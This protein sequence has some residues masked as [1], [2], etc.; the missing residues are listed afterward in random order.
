[1]Y[2]R[3]DINLLVEELE[4]KLYIKAITETSDILPPRVGLNLIPFKDA[5]PLMREREHIYG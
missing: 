5:F 3:L 4:S 2:Q 1:M